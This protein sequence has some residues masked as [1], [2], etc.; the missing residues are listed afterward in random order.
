MKKLFLSTKPQETITEK[1]IISSITNVTNSVTKGDETKT[2]VIKTEQSQTKSEIKE[3]TIENKGQSQIDRI[4]KLLTII[5]IIAG[6]IWTI[7]MFYLKD[8]PA[9][10]ISDHISAEME[11]DSVDINKIHV[12]I[13]AKITNVG[14]QSFD[15]DS[16]VI[17]Y[18]ELPFD[19]I[20]NMTYF[21]VSKFLEDTKVKPQHWNDN[22]LKGYFGINDYYDQVYDFFLN[23][24]YSKSIFFK[25]KY[26]IRIHKWYIFHVPK[27][28]DYFVYD[29][30]C[31][32]HK[33]QLNSS[34]EKS[35]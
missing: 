11:L 2:N 21:S 22:S 1:N 18:W 19:S 17:S 30:H 8:R 20:K 33:K 4:I 27:P 32:P 25:L 28:D 16:V 13:T 26:Y 24:D 35:K 3:T 34:E 10:Y 29:F 12:D 9:L 6:A 14:K 15:L 7:N 23:R 31:A 5:G